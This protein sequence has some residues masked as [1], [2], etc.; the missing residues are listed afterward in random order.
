MEC[1]T[2]IAL[3]LNEDVPGG[4]FIM[5]P[6]LWCFDCFPQWGSM[7]CW[8]RKESKLISWC[9]IRLETGWNLCCILNFQ[10]CWPRAVWCAKWPIHLKIL[11]STFSTVW[12]D[13]AFLQ[14]LGFQLSCTRKSVRCTLHCSCMQWSKT[15]NMFIGVFFLILWERR[16]GW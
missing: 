1:K 11:S 16:P 14:G 10:K 15:M 5:D 4:K 3:L 6:F 2:A 9:G 8:L 13:A 12:K 7:L